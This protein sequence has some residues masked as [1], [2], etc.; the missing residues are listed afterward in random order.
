MGASDAIV[1]TA[2]GQL[3]QTASPALVRG[4]RRGRAL[5]YLERSAEFLDIVEPFIAAAESA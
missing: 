5:P 1:S 2:Y 3:S 4:H